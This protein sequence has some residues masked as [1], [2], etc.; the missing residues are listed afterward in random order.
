M[1]DH[2]DN[3]TTLLPRAVA[4]YQAGDYVAAE[5]HARALLQAGAQRANAATLLGMALE[6]QRR[7]V[8]AVEAF[9]T[10]ALAEPNQASHWINVGTAARA[11]GWH[12]EALAAYT[13][14]A[15][16]GEHSP[17]FQ[18]NVALLHLDR[19][20]Y[21]SAQAL[22]EQAS[23]ARPQDG[24]IRVQ[25]ASCL[26]DRV[27]V[28]EAVAALRD[29][30]TLEGLNTR[31]VARIALLLLNLGESQA[32]DAALQ[33]LRAAP[34]R[35]FDAEL[36]LLQMLERT[37][38]VDEARA[39]LTRLRDAGAA[40]VLGDDLLRA[41]AQLAQRS[42]TPQAAVTA[43]GGIVARC[44][45]PYRL[46][47]DQYPLAK[48]LDACGEYERAFE[49]LVAAHAS[50]MELLARTSHDPALLTR[51]PM[52]ITRFGCDPADV[53]AWR[54]APEAIA[55]AP[56]EADSPVFIV[57]FPR[58]GT[59][60][61]ELTLDA[62]P[63]L[64]SMDEQPYL[65]HAVDSLNAGGQLYPARLAAATPAQLEAAREVYWQA[66]RRR[67]QLQPGQRLIDKNPL[68]MLRLPAIARL[69]PRSRILL[70][71]R[72]P[73]D[74]LLSCYMQHFRAPEFAAMCRDL[75]RLA[76]GWRRAFDFWFEQQ[77]LLRMPVREVR[78]ETLVEQFDTEVHAILDFLGLPW[79]ES[80]REPAEHARRKGY[81]STPSYAQV[82]Q[83]VT[84]R[85][86]G[87]WRHY[88]RHIRP[89]LEDLKPYL[90]RWSYEP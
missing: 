87:R 59:T 16:L 45:E 3:G 21:E 66:V 42:G 57:A 47:F 40:Q 8:E 14:A 69:W 50:Q 80:L 27:L 78:Y 90:A 24:E 19:G 44:T 68:N 32:A 43:L 29:W 23:R 13:R 46:H 5:Q 60:L 53:A 9:T 62:H 28:D 82:V 4:A 72:H 77:A 10:A 12:D 26:Y 18:Y 79:H 76:L 54:D 1:S 74:V 56:A 15:Q 64:A 71:L 63:Q 31:L 49:T 55:A 51:P 30:P 73:G 65:Q 89:V 75:P 83:P 6:A 2:A 84:N 61:L 17:D 48:A 38:R 25:L 85:S 37:N 33:Q 7:H 20:D 58:S 52:G 39:V 70:A 34:D 36:Q 67:V 11:A 86:V 41:E 88:E 22:L 81:I 35:D